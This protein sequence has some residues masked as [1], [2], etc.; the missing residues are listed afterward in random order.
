LS[1]IKLFLLEEVRDRRYNEYAV[2]LQRAFRKFNAVK[3]YQKIKMEASSL[4]LNQKERRSLSINRKFYGDYIGLDHYPSLKALIPKREVIEFAQKC[5]KYD[6]KFKRMMRDVILTNRAIYV[7]GRQE[8]KSNGRKKKVEVV[9][10][11]IEFAQIN[12][13]VLR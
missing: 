12:K 1:R 2:V 8:T 11:K 4:V 7:V 3:Y 13:V 6:R 5:N 10:R 9:K